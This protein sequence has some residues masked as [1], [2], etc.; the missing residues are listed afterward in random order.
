MRSHQRSYFANPNQLLLVN[1]DTQLSAASGSFRSQSKDYI[2]HLCLTP[3]K[4]SSICALLLPRITILPSKARCRLCS[5]KGFTGGQSGTSPKLH[6][7]Q[8]SCLVRCYLGTTPFTTYRSLRG[9]LH[10][11][12]KDKCTGPICHLNILVCV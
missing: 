2:S 11:N 8:E 12:I 10:S 6:Q 7:V 9:L 5:P 4:S 3:S 1:K